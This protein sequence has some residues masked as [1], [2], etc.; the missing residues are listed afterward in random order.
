MS[1]QPT[2]SEHPRP[3]LSDAV[4]DPAVLAQIEAALGEATAA[5]GRADG[6]VESGERKG[7]KD[8]GDKSKKLD[9]FKIIHDY[10]RRSIEFADRK[11]TFVVFGANAFAS[12]LDRS[13]GLSGA[14]GTPMAEWSIG[15][16]CGEAAILMLAAGGFTALWVIVPRVARKAPKGAIYWEAIRQHKSFEEWSAAMGAIT[17]DD[18]TRIV[19]RGIYDLAAINVTKYRTLQLAT[20]LGGIG[21][22]LALLHIAL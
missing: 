1:E 6:E 11:A 21:M 14:R 16:W 12:F 22:V 13:S 18:A 19:L 4:A 3:R 20:W 9:L 2:A 10:Q 8:K 17:E 7:K 5:D 15:T